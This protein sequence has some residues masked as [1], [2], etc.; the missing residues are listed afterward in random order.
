M[1]KRGRASGSTPRRRR[2]RFKQVLEAAG[3][4]IVAGED[5]CILPKAIKTAAE[6]KGARAAHLR[7]GAAVSRFLAWLDEHSPSGRVDEISAAMK[8]EDFRRETGRAQG[9]QFRQHLRCGPAWRRGALPAHHRE[10]SEAQ[11]A[12]A[13]S[14]SIP[15]ANMP[16]APP[17]S[18]G[19]SPSARQAPKCDGITRWCSR[20]I[21]PLPQRGSRKE[22]ADR[23]SIR[24]R[25]GRCGRPG[26]TRPRNRS[27]RR[28]LSLGAR[29][30]PAHLAARHRR[31]SARHDLV[32]RARALS[33]GRIWHQA[34]KSRAGDDRRQRSK[35][36]RARCS[37]SRR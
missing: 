7:D 26:S 14:S 34:G 9:H 3:A 27:W 37:A 28:Q 16:T 21:S 17:T 13:L 19:P 6:I 4:K 29:A 15:V 22:P 23:T 32:Q 2:V 11:A 10:Q 33:R 5:P 12:L 20:D 1:V 31:A 36:A 8:L 18:R 24:S 25:G 30:A 35:A